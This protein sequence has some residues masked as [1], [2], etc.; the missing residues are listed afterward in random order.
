MDKKGFTL[1]EI[2]IVVAIIGIIATMALPNYFQVRQTALANSCIANLKEIRNAVQIWAM[3]TGAA[4]DATPGATSDLAPYVKT[5][6]HCGSP[7]NTYEI[8]SVDTNPVCPVA[9]SRATHHL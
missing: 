3:D 1:V 9:G 6:P 2:M 5:W 7:A 4:S 8:P